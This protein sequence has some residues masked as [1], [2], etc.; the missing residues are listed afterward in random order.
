MINGN[1]A[2]SSTNTSSLWRNLPGNDMAPSVIFG[3][4]TV[5][6]AVPVI[7]ATIMFL[8][9][10]ICAVHEVVEWVREKN[11]WRTGTVLVILYGILIPLTD[12]I[13]HGILK[14]WLRC[15]S[16]LGQGTITFIEGPSIWIA[17]TLGLVGSLIMFWSLMRRGHRGRSY[18]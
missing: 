9:I 1:I 8:C 18:R 7:L 10:G 14:L 15:T 13:Q 5:G 3:W 2:L 6:L 11:K 4:S 16:E 17:P 12:H